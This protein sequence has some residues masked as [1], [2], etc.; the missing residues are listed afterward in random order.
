MKDQRR[1]KKKKREKQ[2]AKRETD[3]E[4]RVPFRKPKAERSLSQIAQ[5]ADW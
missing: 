4:E 1:K 3:Q 2:K 5:E